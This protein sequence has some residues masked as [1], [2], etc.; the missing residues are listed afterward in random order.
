MDSVL[1][2]VIT[3]LDKNGN[4]ILLGAQQGRNTYPTKKEAKQG[5][6]DIYDNNSAQTIA[7]FYGEPLEVRLCRCYQ[8]HFDPQEIYF[9]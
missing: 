6:K 8:G 2:Y 3:H 9:D 4:R 1:R 5:I 7:E